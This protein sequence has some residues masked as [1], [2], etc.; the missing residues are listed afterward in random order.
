MK[1]I[2]CILYVYDTLKELEKYHIFKINELF[3]IKDRKGLTH[4]IPLT[5]VLKSANISFAL[6]SVTAS[7]LL[8]IRKINDC[9]GIY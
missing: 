4:I 1:T 9:K 2:K 8:M 7:R 3:K 6:Y 5:T